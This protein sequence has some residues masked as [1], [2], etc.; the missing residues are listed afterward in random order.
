MVLAV[1]WP[2][3][4]TPW[5]AL[6]V[7]QNIGRKE[8]HVKKNDPQR[9]LV[10]RTDRMGDVM[11][12]LPVVSALKDTFPG[13]GVDMLLHPSTCE[14]VEGHPHVRNIVID[15]DAGIHAGLRGFFRLARSL[16]NRKYDLAVLVHPTLRLAL[17]LFLAGIPRRIGT[18]YRWYQ[19]LFNEKA[20]EHRRDAKRHEAEYNLNL[21]RPL[22]I[23]CS[24]VRFNIV[25][26]PRAFEKVD[27]ML[28]TCGLTREDRVAILH[29]GSGGSA[30][31]WPAY[32]FAE[33]GDTL[34][35]DVDLKV[36]I[37]G[38]EEEVGLVSEVANRMRAEPLLEACHLTIKELA[39]LIQRAHVFVSNSTG[40]MHI[41][42][43]VGTPVVALFPPI[44]PCS[45]RR[46]GPYGEGHIVMSPKVPECGKCIEQR[47]SYFDCMDL[48]NIDEVFNAVR[49]V[50]ERQMK[51]EI[52]K[53]HD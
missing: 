46:W 30:R 23:H 3:N 28:H 33:L 36:I 45:P 4:L 9:I 24:D 8:G 31:D 6:S 20:Y 14:I 21:L 49:V 11:L 40:P 51:G 22:G 29:P 38:S 34:M 41:A 39:A 48:I 25:I 50:L 10:L 16:R 35:D 18:G 7:L 27:G 12:T 15:D 19:F 13:S 42:A 37:T 32:K 26:P 1:F 5:E 43:A 53:I 2:V 52:L 44:I 47:C 17:L